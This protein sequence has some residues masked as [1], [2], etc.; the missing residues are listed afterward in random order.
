LPCQTKIA[1]C[2]IYVK[3]YIL[4]FHQIWKFL[5]KSYLTTKHKQ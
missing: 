3:W 4:S 5:S 1:Y 2:A